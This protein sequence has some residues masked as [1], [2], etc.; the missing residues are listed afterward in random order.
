[1][2]VP[3]ASIATDA[4][5]NEINSAF[6]Q[7]TSAMGDKYN[8]SGTI[9]N[10][11]SSTLPSAAIAL[12][13]P[14]AAPSVLA[15]G[16]TSGI[17]ALMSN[18][19]YWTTFTMTYGD[20]Y[21]DLI[22]KGADPN[23]A[24][25]AALTATAINSW[26]EIGGGVETLPGKL[27]SAPVGTNKFLEWF[28]SSLEEGGEEILQ[29]N[30]SEIFSRL[31][32]GDFEVTQDRFNEFAINNLKEGVMGAIAGGAL[33]GGQF[34]FNEIVNYKSSQ[35]YSDIGK[36]LKSLGNGLQINGVLDYSKT[37]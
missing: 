16:Y 15:S 23:L 35:Q 9:L 24:F 8:I 32:T 20:S 5:A 6:A 33:G 17:M 18:P 30:V 13:V 3:K 28:K 14:A 36:Y 22:E 25:G 27:A 4:K 26:I 31:A 11:V 29:G 10:A 1:M 7:N 2:E 37:S 12:V 19:M 21:Y 34:A